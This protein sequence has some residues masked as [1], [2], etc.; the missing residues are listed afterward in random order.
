MTATT[1]TTPVGRLVQGDAFVAQTTDQQGAPRLVKTGPNAGQPNPQFYIGVAFRKDDPAWPAFFA[2]LDAQA[3]A[4]FPHLFPTP[5]AA[6]VN[7]LFS[8]KIIDGDGLDTG[9]KKWSD[10][11]G[12]AGHWVVRFASSFAPKVFNAGQYDPMQQVTDPRALKRGYYV[13]VNGSCS[14]NGNAQRP[15]LYLNL[16]LI[17][18]SAIGPEIVSGPNA[19]EAF[20][21][22]SPAPLP[23]GATPL[24]VAP[25]P[26]PVAAPAPAPA[27]ASP[28]PVAA[29]PVTASPAPPPAPAAPAPAPAT[30]VR[31][32][33]AAANGVTYEAH[34]AA[35]WTDDQLV[36]NGLMLPQ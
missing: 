1:F 32:M 7:P 33:T 27:A 16:N 23:A 30:P 11:E 36:A 2:L 8:F 26:Q 28:S 3:R 29:S 15:G 17:E 19:S 12:F 10:R 25:A 18:I 21:G 24:A 34:I 4:D 14:G 5:G 6:C 35:G 22:G 31:Q 9:G 13:R 20:G